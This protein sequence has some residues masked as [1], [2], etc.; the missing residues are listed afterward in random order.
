MVGVG[1]NVDVVFESAPSNPRVWHDGTTFY[2][3]PGKSRCNSSAASTKTFA[4]HSIAGHA[5]D[6]FGHVVLNE[7][8]SACVNVPNCV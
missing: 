3:I 4:I 1:F 7:L 8:L 2:Q 6:N 5:D